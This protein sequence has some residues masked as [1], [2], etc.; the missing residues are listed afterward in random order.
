MGEAVL[1]VLATLLG[2]LVGAWGSRETQRSAERIAERQLSESRTA[3]ARRL[4]AEA[5]ARAREAAIKLHPINIEDS[6]PLQGATTEPQYR[7]G[8]EQLRAAVPVLHQLSVLLAPT[9][10]GRDAGH[11]AAL[12]MQM[13]EGWRSGRYWAEQKG[14]RSKELFSRSYELIE[15]ARREL[16]GYSEDYTAKELP[17]LLGE[18]GGALERLRMSLGAVG[19]ETP[20]RK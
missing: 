2:A 17:L 20:R 18:H 1:A 13:D 16:L 12:L 9:D 7:E 10:A 8:S 15:A 14:D 5:Y 19:S 3:E 6:M 4:G 11:V